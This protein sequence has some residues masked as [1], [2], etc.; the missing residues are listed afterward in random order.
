MEN[1]YKTNGLI[2]SAETNCIDLHVLN[3]AIRASSVPLSP[4]WLIPNPFSIVFKSF[5]DG[6]LA[7]LRLYRWAN[8]LWSTLV[9]PRWIMC[10]VFKFVFFLV[11]G[12]LPVM[13][14]VETLL[15][16]AEALPLVNGEGGGSPRELELIAELVKRA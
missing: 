13:E 5:A 1:Y 3:S 7:T 9:E 11:S 4:A 6:M 12:V 14:E 2:P 16:E 10:V 8:K 15:V